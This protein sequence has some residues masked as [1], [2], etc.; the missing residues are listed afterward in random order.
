MTLSTVMALIV[1][2]ISATGVTYAATP[3]FTTLQPGQ[4]R[5]INQTLPIN[6]VFVGYEQGTGPRDINES[7]FRFWLP[8]TYHSVNRIP[9]DVYGLN[10][11]TGLAFNYSYNLVYA[12]AAFE[13][14]FFGY[15]N[16]IAQA[17]P[18]TIL[19]EWYNTQHARSLSVGQNYEIDATS[20]EKWLGNNAPSL[21]GID[22]T[23]YTVFFVNWYGRPDFKFHV[24]TKLNE[25]DVDTGLNRGL[26]DGRKMIAWGGT[27]ADDPEGGLGTLRRVWFYDLS[28]GPE[29]FSDNWNVDDA[30]VNLDGFLDYRMPPVWEYG[31]QSGYRPFINLSQDLGW[32]SRFVA[33]DLLFTTSPLYK[34]AISPPKLPS[35]IQLDIN[36]YQGDPTVDGKA[37]LNQEHILSKLRPLQPL[38]SFSA[39]VKEIRFSG[40]AANVYLSWLRGESSFGNR[41]KLPAFA[42]LFLYHNDHLLQ[43]LTGDADYEVPIFAYNTTTADRGFSSFADD[44]W[45]NGTQSF[46]FVFDDPFLRSAAGFGLSTSVIHE[47]G[48]HLGMSHPHDGFD[49]ESNLDFSPFYFF[50]FAWSGDESNTVMSYLYNNDDFSQFDRDNMNRYLTATYIN[51][52]NKVLA[53]IVASPKANDV[54][55]QLSAADQQATTALTI[56]QTMDYSSALFYAKDAYQKVSSA[57]AQINIPF[58]REAWPA[59]YKA[60]GANYMFTDDFTRRRL[61]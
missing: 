14:A 28:A 26:N 40:T 42:D 38:N 32:V 17:Q 43:F 30:D 56:Y 37:F 31:N 45:A 19:Q 11:P 18:R 23:Q 44:N 35:N 21:L 47:V 60:H 5:E 22:T 54:A 46:V 4:F 6:I 20:T 57:A 61:P 49:S 52:A 50:D 33:I 10:S 34:A 48:H 55:A 1:L 24:Y 16:S 59:D 53:K 58:E 3:T 8:Q 12:N 27:S 36:L 15:M 9:N 25:P 41:L 13:N 7:A 39:E 2:L 29:Y 51:E